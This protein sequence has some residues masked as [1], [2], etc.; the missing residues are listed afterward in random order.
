MDKPLPHEQRGI[1]LA[2]LQSVINAIPDN[3]AVIDS[4]GIIQFVNDAWLKFGR[5]NGAD[6]ENIST[7]SNY[8]QCCERACESGGEDKACAEMVLWGLKRV[9][10]DNRPDFRFNYPCHSGVEKRWFTLRANPLKIGDDLYCLT[11]HADISKLMVAQAALDNALLDAYT[12]S[13]AKS[14]FLATMSHEL[15]TPLNAVLGY[16]GMMNEEVH[17]PVGNDQYRE[18]LRLVHYS[19]ERLLSLVDDILDLNQVERGEYA[20]HDQE[21]DV[22]QELESFRKFYAPGIINAPGSDV[23][24]HVEAGAPRLRADARAFSQIVENLVSNAL[25]FSGDKAEVAVSW[26]RTENGGGRLQV[27]DNG[28]GIPTTDLLKITEPFVRLH[29]PQ[30]DNPYVSD[31]KPGVGL[32]LHIVSRIAAAH[33]ARLR[34]ESNLGEGTTVYVD[35]PPERTIDPN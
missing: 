24:I 15:R 7:G 14:S 19:G 9:I 30:N 20:F 6:T 26:S 23:S 22:R 13:E 28:P 18:Y 33:Q 16:T 21:M 27:A 5:D 1:D 3:I 25:K 17:G 8:F 11:S 31:R 35:F 4:D 10:N 32:G 29:T 2:F 12:A 34:L